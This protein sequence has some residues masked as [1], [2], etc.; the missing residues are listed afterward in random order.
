MNQLN[1]FKCDIWAFG[2]LAWEILLDGKHYVDSLTT[3]H[4][5]I[6]Q[7]DGSLVIDKSL[8]LDFA[9]A[10]VSEIAPGFK[11]PYLR[12][13]FIVT[14]QCDPA[15]RTSD[16]SN[17][18]IMTKWHDRARVKFE[19]KIQ[20]EIAEWSYEMFRPE[21]G[22]EVAWEYQRQILTELSRFYETTQDLQLR[23]ASAWQIAIFHVLGFGAPASQTS[24]SSFAKSAEDMGHPIAR[25]MFPLV[26]REDG[27]SAPLKSYESILASGF[28]HSVCMWSS[29]YV[30]IRQLQSPLKLEKLKI[31]SLRDLP[32]DQMDSLAVSYRQIDFESCPTELKSFDNWTQAR[33]QLS[34]LLESSHSAWAAESLGD[35]TISLV[36]TL[37]SH[38]NR[39]FTILEVAVLHGDCDLVDALCAKGVDCNAEIMTLALDPI[40]VQACLLGN[41]KMVLCLLKNGADP[42]RQ[43]PDGC[44]M[45]HWFFTLDTSGITEVERWIQRSRLSCTLDL[46]STKPRYLHRQWPLGLIGT[47]LAFAISVANTGTVQ[48]LLRLGANPFAHA[49][50]PSQFL[51]TDYRS[52]WTA[53]HLA[54]KYHMKEMIPVLMQYRDGGPPMTT[55]LACALCYSS[56]MER[57]AIHGNHRQ[58]VLKDTIKLLSTYED[59]RDRTEKGFTALTQAIDFQDTDVVAALLDVDQTLATAHLVNPNN[60]LEFEVPIH[61]ASQLAAR[62]GEPRSI[63][64]L[65]L[66][67]KYDVCTIDQVDFLGR[68]PLHFSVTGSSPSAAEWLLS[69]RPSLLGIEDRRG[70]TA[71][72]FCRSVATMKLLLQRGTNQNHTDQTG[73]AP[74]HQFCL[75]ASLDMVQSFLAYE[76][77]LKLSNNIYGSPLHCAVMKRSRPLSVAL[78]LAGMSVNMQNIQGD[79]ALIVATRFGYLP[80]LQL[81]LEHD[82]DIHIQNLLGETALHAAV[83]FRDPNTKS[84]HAL[85]VRELLNNGANPDICDKH[86]RTPLMSASASG[87]DELVRVLLEKNADLHIEDILGQTALRH[88]IV[89]GHERVVRVLLANDA[90]PESKPGQS[91]LRTSLSYAAEK[92]IETMLQIILNSSQSIDLEDNEPK[93][94]LW[95]AV[96]NR[97]EN[98]ARLLL[99]NGANPNPYIGYTEETSLLSFA[100]AQDMESFV[101]LLMLH[102]AELDAR[103]GSDGLTPLCVAAALGRDEIV[104]LLLLKGAHVDYPDASFRTPVVHAII[105]GQERTMLNLLKRGADPND[106]YHQ[107]KHTP[108]VYA[109]KAGSALAVFF[110]IIYG[111]FIDGDDASG[112]TPLSVAAQRG[113]IDIATLLLIRGA[114]IEQAQKHCLRPD[115]LLLVKKIFSVNRTF[116]SLARPSFSDTLPSV[117]KY[118]QFMSTL[119][120][121]PGKLLTEVEEKRLQELLFPS[122]IITSNASFYKK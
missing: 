50:A 117:R 86:G 103:T 113:A 18:S 1:L 75:E 109:V 96:I 93:T 111:A 7:P 28:R 35:Q 119:D 49:Y 72:H 57:K 8:L 4:T 40:L 45:F 120:L 54:A 9:K 68:T 106:V 48:A 60:H 52:T 78:L 42:S 79:T 97:N 13:V 19:S 88:A 30:M 58:E 73:L 67:Y 12:H 61:F 63:A 11:A 33:T 107:Q 5:S 99:E 59:L 37:P 2:L 38:R 98:F 17:L 43:G 100:V 110:L 90:H 64:I 116:G 53:V 92:G 77:D 62:N 105:A 118:F 76:P 16:L 89:G 31:I 47:P 121:Y 80:L 104:N 46:P 112:S 94:P 65:K 21:N 122:F 71:L 83:K 69:E 82:A 102:G 24:A 23:S 20:V 15:L 41:T 34:C 108:L 14:L 3:T 26:F 114:S 91:N 36:I 29:Q 74:I 87:E 27:L 70:R 25:L 6:K 66:F 115:D 22:S 55:P 39:S 32:V 51:Q 95:Y 84:R 101:H 85:L 81:L 44:S 56:P 10:S